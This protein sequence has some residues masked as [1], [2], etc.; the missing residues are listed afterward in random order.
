M[1]EAWSSQI[2]FET[3]IILKLALLFT[4]AKLLLKSM[5]GTW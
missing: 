3:C 1:I 4:G 5:H 2:I